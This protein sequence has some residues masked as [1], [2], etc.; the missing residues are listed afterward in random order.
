MESFKFKT[1]KG[2]DIKTY[3]WIPEGEIKAA[4]Q[5]SHGMNE[6]ILRYDEFANFLASK[7]YL[8]YGNDHLGHGES[9]LYGESLGY[10]SDDNGFTDMVDEMRCLTD[11]IKKENNGIKI[12]I[13]AHSMGSFLAQR[14][15]QSYG[16]EIDGLILSGTNGQ[17]P[18]GI[19]LGIALSKLIIKSKGRRYKS[20]M[21]NLLSF[22]S[23][24]KGFKDKRTEFDW[25]S[26]IDE[27]VD[28]YIEDPLCGNL[29]PVS[30]FHDLYMGMKEVHKDENLGQVPKDLPIYIFGGSEDPVGNKGKGIR[31][32]YNIYR[33]YKIEDLDY[34]VYEGGRH[35]MLNE[36]D[37]DKVMK[38]ILNWLESKI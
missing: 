38:D 25:I 10:I 4:V 16:R 6:Y 37:K 2:L 15:I 14:Y 7:G 9:K 21:I 27:E 32:L 36:K 1:N 11:I 24:N 22:G 34:K 29:F 12:F 17:P 18:P 35:E 23:Y 33:D 19:D 13:F 26:S 3:K 20:K 31:N 30:F 8:V 28:K 5:I